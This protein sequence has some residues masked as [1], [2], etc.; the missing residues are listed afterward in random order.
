MV[1]GL[2]SMSKAFT[3]AAIGLVM[4]DFAHGRNVTPLPAGM[5]EFTWNSKVLDLLPGEWG[6]QDGFASQKASVKDIMSHV[7]GLPRSRS[8]HLSACSMKLT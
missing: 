5:T 7:S 6:L 1:V 4:D 8:T 3:A 2:G